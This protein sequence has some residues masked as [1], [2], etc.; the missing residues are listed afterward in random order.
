MKKTKY[1]FICVLLVLTSVSCEK[2]L[3]DITVTINESGVVDIKIID[4]DKQPVLGAELQIRS[5]STGYTIEDGVTDNSGKYVSAKLLQGSYSCFVST[6]KDNRIYSDNATFQIIA[7]ET[8]NIEINPYSNVGN[9]IIKLLEIEGR[10][11]PPLN[12]SISPPIPELSYGGIYGIFPLDDYIKSAYFT[13]KTDTD[14]K[15][16]F[17]D[18]P[19]GQ[20]V[21]SIYGDEGPGRYFVFKHI[22][23]YRAKDYSYKISIDITY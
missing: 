21:V 1:L 17:P 14:N 6:V 12:I 7:G 15:L 3:N 2:E 23:V 8:K 9:G 5:S 16:V 19:V 10:Q 13:G 20:Y 11:L 4:N 22:Y 18:I